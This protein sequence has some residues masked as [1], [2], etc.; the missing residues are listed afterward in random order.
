MWHPQG[1]EAAPRGGRTTRMGSAERPGEEK[2]PAL[3]GPFGGE[4]SAEETPGVKKGASEQ[5]GPEGVARLRLVENPRRGDG[6][7]WGEA[8]R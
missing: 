8:R 4:S 7:S 3:K 6:E 5:R 2:D 1:E